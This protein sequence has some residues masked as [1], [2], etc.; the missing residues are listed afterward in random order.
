MTFDRVAV[1]E[2]ALD[3]LLADLAPAASRLLPDEPLHPGSGLTAR[4]AIELFEDQVLSRQVD[5]AARELKKTNRSFHTIGGAGH[6]N[7]AAHCL[8]AYWAS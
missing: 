2:D 7:R 5:R 4:R 6:E 3:A 8:R 1:V